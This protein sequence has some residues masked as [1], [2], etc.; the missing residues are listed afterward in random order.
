MV[1]TTFNDSAHSDFWRG[2][3]A[4]KMYL[5]RGYQEDSVPDR[6]PPGTTC[7]L[8]L[9]VW[10]VSE[11]LLHAERLA[12]RFESEAV[13][14]RVQ[15]RGSRGR[16]LSTW[17]SPDRM[18]MQGRISCQ[19]TV[20]S[21][22]VVPAGSISETLPDVVRPLVE[23]LYAAFDFFKPP[24]SLYREEITKMRSRG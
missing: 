13:E 3:P 9:P 24:D 15:W 21:T 12:A 6:T 1:E 8:S 22:A 14:V 10:R 23:P 2:D 5:L 19:D 11:C 17:A 4:A 18:L 16:E 7:D 20:T